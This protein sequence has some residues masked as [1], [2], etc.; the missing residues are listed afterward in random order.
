MVLPLHVLPAGTT[1]SGE[2]TVGRAAGGRLVGGA[3]S[4]FGW[5]APNGVDLVAPYGAAAIRSEAQNGARLSA[6][7]MVPVVLVASVIFLWG[8]TCFEG[9]IMPMRSVP[10][11]YA[12]DMVE[13]AAADSVG[14]PH[15]DEDTDDQ[16]SRVA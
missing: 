6:V 8:A 15:V 3:H 16:E 1:V 12:S 13:P 2:A 14:R 7:W 5:L 10:K 4:R 9:W 11:V